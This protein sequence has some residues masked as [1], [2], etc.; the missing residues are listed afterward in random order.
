MTVI[1]IVGNQAFSMINFRGTLIEALVAKGMTVYA[2]VPELDEDSE[3]AIRKLGAV[4]V[5]IS[6]SRT[7]TNPLADLK[8][9][10]SIV[11]CMIRLKPDLIL[12]YA[13]KPVI[14]GIVAAW[15]A[16]V[17]KRFS[18]IEGLGYVFISNPRDGVFKTAVRWL[19][20]HLYRFSFKRSNRVFFLNDDDIS[21]FV[22]MRLLSQSKPVKIGGIGV[23]LS[24]WRPAPPQLTP[25]TFTMVARLLRD[26]GVIEFVEAARIIKSENP[27]VR[28]VLVG[29]RD[30]NPE[31]VTE[32][33]LS[34]WVNAGLV[35]WTG[36]VPVGPH[37]E[38][39]SV[40]VLPSYREGV[41]RSTQEAMAMG[42]AVITTDVP[43]CR[44]TVIDGQN[45]FLIEPRDTNALAAA[46][47]KFIQKPELIA[48]MGRRSRELAEERF[49]ATKVNETIIRVLELKYYSDR[50]LIA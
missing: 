2:L 37:L 32:T 17:P 23:D 27:G 33:Q 21:D 7:G 26:K 29:G 31:S 4:P 12:A 8:S 34:D 38:H 6:L 46:M 50:T 35:E 41:P 48:T 16:G 28:F 18:M 36:H 11:R 24:Q 3:S 13:A 10:I 47:H 30:K 15:I 40:F 25:I 22:H 43:G 39:T 1:T 45:G 44:E 42:R 49:D 9:L 14:Y 19:V 20:K 5:A